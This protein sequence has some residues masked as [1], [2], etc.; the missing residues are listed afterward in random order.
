M[1]CVVFF[2]EQ[3]RQETPPYSISTLK[4]RFLHLRFEAKER[5]V[6]SVMSKYGRDI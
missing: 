5:Q 6:T 3:R 4:F 1:T 2:T